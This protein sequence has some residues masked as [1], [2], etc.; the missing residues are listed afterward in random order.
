MRIVMWG[1]GLL[2]CG[3]A[4]G[5]GPTA[6]VS[7]AQAADV[8][9]QLLTRAFA[10]FSD[11]IIEESYAKNLSQSLTNELSARGVH[12][13]ARVLTGLELNDAAVRAEIDKFNPDGVLV[14]DLVGGTTTQFNQIVYMAYSATLI[15]DERRVWKARIEADPGAISTQK[16]QMREVAHQLVLQLVK[17]GYVRGLPEDASAIAQTEKRQNRK[18]IRAN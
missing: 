4:L 2:L 7:S 1:T 5:C 8:K 13:G 3:L 15:I 18:N 10:I 11:Q 9:P 16:M 12:A 17:D 14:I 6:K